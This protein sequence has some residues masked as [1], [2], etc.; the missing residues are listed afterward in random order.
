MSEPVSDERNCLELD[1]VSAAAYRE[2]IQIGTFSRQELG[3][4]MELPSEEV[5]RAERVLRRLRLLQAMPGAPDVLVPVNP[6]VASA[7]LVGP[8]DEEVHRIQRA[9]AEIRSQLLSL[10]PVYFEARR[11][12]NEVEAFDIVSDADTVQSMLDHYR[13]R[14]RSEVLDVQP[15]RP[16]YGAESDR[17]GPSMLS[18]LERG[19][20]L[21]TIYQHTAR[22]D[23]T[24]IAYVRQITA[25]GAHVR[26]TEELVDRMVVYDREVAFL[27]AQSARGGGSGAVVVKE[28]NLVAFICSLFNYF[29]SRSV[30]FAPNTA[31]PAPRT[32]DL[33]RSILRL[34]ANGYKDEMVARRLGMSV[35]T[36]RRHISDLTEELK[37]TSRFQAGVI[38]AQRGLIDGQPEPGAGWLDD[39]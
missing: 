20:E 37:A 8:L 27:P 3:D 6:D 1:D 28:P 2:A 25:R 19:V 17:P 4:R 10:V 38:A 34:M 9:A 35:R 33:K 16:R 36:C 15:A 7:D 5:V 30:P 11:R 18:A 12:R 13:R 29:W 39:R 14:C 22:G 23:L 26:T 32:D 24:T 21:R 31:S